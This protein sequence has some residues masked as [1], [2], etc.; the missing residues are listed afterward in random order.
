MLREAMHRTRKSFKATL[1]DGLRAGL[2][3]RP[4]ATKPTPFVVKARPL[5][6]RAGI[7][8]ARFN[9]LADDLEVEAF[10]GKQTRARRP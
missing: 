4:A 5:G 6:L 10:V 8:P 7:D 1:N 3:G 9:H 2:G